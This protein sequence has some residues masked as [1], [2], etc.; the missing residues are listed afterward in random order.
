MTTFT[1]NHRV[2]IENL[3]AIERELQ[4][5]GIPY[6]VKPARW[7][8]WQEFMYLASDKSEYE[9]RSARSENEQMRSICCNLGSNEFSR[10]VAKAKNVPWEKAEWV[11]G[12]RESYI[13]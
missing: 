11:V 4:A 10:L 1:R 7:S 13:R 8:A 3:P 2:Y 9:V 6:E 5:Q 12:H